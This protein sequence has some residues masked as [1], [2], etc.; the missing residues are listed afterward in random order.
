LI[1]L[2]HPELERKIDDREVPGAHT[3]RAK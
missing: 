3:K 1:E 2:D